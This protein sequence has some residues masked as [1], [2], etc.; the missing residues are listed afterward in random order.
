MKERRSKIPAPKRDESF[1]IGFLPASKI[2]DGDAGGKNHR[3]RQA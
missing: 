1:S 2:V 3:G